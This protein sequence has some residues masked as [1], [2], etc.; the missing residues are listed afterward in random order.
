MVAITLNVRP[1]IGSRYVRHAITAN[2]KAA[3][4]A[5]ATTPA[6]ASE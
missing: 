2:S 1:A 4:P 6:V 5:A 3:K